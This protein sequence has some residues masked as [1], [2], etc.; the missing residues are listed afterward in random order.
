LPIADTRATKMLGFDAD[1]DPVMSGST[2]TDIDASVAAAFAGGV[3]ASS[4]QFTGTGSQ[5]AFTITGGVTA[6]PNAQAL[7]ITIDGVTQHTDTYTTAA[8]VVTFSTA[9]PLNADIQIRYNAYLGTATDAASATYNQGGTGA[10]SRTIENKLQESVSVLD[11]GATGDGVTD[12]TAAIQAALTASKYVFIPA[13]TYIVTGITFQQ[14][15]QVLVG[16]TSTTSILKLKASANTYVLDTNEKSQIRIENLLLDGNRDNNTTSKGL[17]VY[18]SYYTTIKD[19]DIRYTDDY[20]VYGE[21]SYVVE[22]INLRCSHSDVS[23]NNKAIYLDVDCKHWDF[24]GGGVESITGGSNYAIYSQG[25]NCTFSNMWI[26]WYQGDSVTGN[27]VGIYANNTHNFVNNC[28]IK[29]SS[30]TVMGKGVHF[31][32]SS[33]LCQAHNNSLGN[34]TNP[35]YL[36]GNLRS[37]IIR[38][39]SSDVTNVDADN[40]TL[41]G[42][43]AD[44]DATDLRVKSLYVST[45]DGYTPSGEIDTSVPAPIWHANCENDDSGLRINITGTDANTDNLFRV[46]NNGTTKFEIDHFGNSFPGADGTLDSGTASKR[47]DT[48]YATTGT[49]NTSDA[50]EKQ[51]VESL[52]DAENTV[53]TSLKGMIK[54]FKFNNAVEAKGDSARIHVGVI[55]QDVQQAFT[56]A[57]LNP[58]DYGVFCSDTWWVDS[59]DKTYDEAGEGRTEKTRLGVR[60]EELF[61]FIISAL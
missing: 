26:E 33:N 24:I 5:V 22:A 56:D 31:A 18:N 39:T 9:P 4:Y 37:R 61:A 25:K 41:I 34:I 32:G 35:I 12:D 16:E 13:G 20:L 36:E 57:G 19:I 54:K 49:I 43:G 30:T 17:R 60:Y 23:T 55:A 59:E 42:W 11:F 6:I 28:E 7:I 46:Q 1:G 48:I 47:W 51:Q 29:S 58:G 14:V 15:G 40:T 45:N 2:M 27:E 8:A 10:S 52:S 3:L 21:H 44:L 50:N 53:A 38:Q